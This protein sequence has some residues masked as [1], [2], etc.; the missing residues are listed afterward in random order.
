V[1]QHR[2]QQLAKLYSELAAVKKSKTFARRAREKI[3]TFRSRLA[4]GKAKQK[5]IARLLNFTPTT[6]AH[7]HWQRRTSFGERGAKNL[8]DPSHFVSL[9]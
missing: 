4:I 3:L 1:F 9:N 5:T 7:T 8:L 2:R 6:T